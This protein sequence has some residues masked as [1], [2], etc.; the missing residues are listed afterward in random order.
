MLEVPVEEGN[1]LVHKGD[2]LFR[3]DPTPYQ[4]DV[5][6]L[7]AQLALAQGGQRETEESLTGANAK[8]AEARAAI[9]QAESRGSAEVDARL[10]PRAKA[11]RAEPGARDVRRRQP[12]RP[13]AGRSEPRPS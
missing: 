6:N 3:V 11:R 2:V 5:A 12:L 13:R 4:L 10:G 9:A 7:E 1:R 8:V